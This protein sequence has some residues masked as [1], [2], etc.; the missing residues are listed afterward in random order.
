MSQA[1]WN[2]R[3]CVLLSDGRCLTSLESAAGA[4]GVPQ[5]APE[6]VTD[7]VWDY[8]LLEGPQPSNSRIPDDILQRCAAEFKYWYPFDLRV[9]LPFL[10]ECRPGAGLLC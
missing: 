10:L 7:E 3:Q 9:R 4:E 8:L 1:A 5:I 2:G 6:D